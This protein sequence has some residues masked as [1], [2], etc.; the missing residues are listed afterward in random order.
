MALEKHTKDGEKSI[1]WSFGR[2]AST[3][4]Q[5]YWHIYISPTLLKLLS[6]ACSVLSVLSLLGVVGSITVVDYNVSLYW[7]LV[8]QVFQR[9]TA[10]VVFVLITLG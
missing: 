6:V 7:K 9:G 2:E 8:H 4:W 10:I 3:G 1:K 5:F